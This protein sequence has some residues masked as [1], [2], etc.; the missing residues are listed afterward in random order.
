MQAMEDDAGVVPNDDDAQEGCLLHP[1]H[2]VH[3]GKAREG[4]IK[5][6]ANGQKMDIKG[7]P[8]CRMLTRVTSLQLLVTVTLA[9]VC[10]TRHGDLRAWLA[11][12]RVAP[13]SAV[14]GG[15]CTPR[16]VDEDDDVQEADQPPAPCLQG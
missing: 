11:P 6:A 14:L 5:R 2:V 10:C 12:A 13:T 15:V 9:N 16:H 8:T 4:S 3:D 1:R 7:M